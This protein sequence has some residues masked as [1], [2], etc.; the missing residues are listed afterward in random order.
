MRQIRS[1]TVY[2]YQIL[3]PRINIII[4]YCAIEV[5]NTEARNYEEIGKN[6]FKLF[7]YKKNT[8]LLNITPYSQLKAN[9]RFRG[10]YSLHLQ[11]RISRSRYQSE[12]RWLS[13]TSVDLHGV[14]SQKIILLITTAERTSNPAN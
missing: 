2:M 14:I 10:T 4:Q 11:G 9:R 6:T 3:V 1:N 5:V 12:S 8:I 13:E 7:K